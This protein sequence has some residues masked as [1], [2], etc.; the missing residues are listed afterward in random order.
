MYIH[1]KAVTYQEQALLYVMITIMN[2]QTVVTYDYL[3]WKLETKKVLLD[4]VLQAANPGEK[5]VIS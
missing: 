2:V 3:R 5:L 4:V 1:H